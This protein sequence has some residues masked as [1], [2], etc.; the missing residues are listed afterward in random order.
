MGFLIDEKRQLFGLETNKTTYAFAVDNMGL[1]RHL[2]W[3][4]KVNN[5]ED[6]DVPALAEMSS[7]DPILDLTDEEYPVFG[8]MR[9]KEHCLKVNFAD[10]TRDIEYRYV[11]YTQTEET[12]VIHL[13]DAHYEFEFDLHYKVYEVQDLIERTVS[14]R[15]TGNDIIEIEKVHSGQIHLPYQDLTLTSSHGRWL[16]EFQEFKQPLGQ[17]KIVLENRRGISTHHHNP[18]FILD[19]QA[20]ETN[21][22][23]Y[24]GVLKLS[25][26]F[27]TIIEPRPYGGTLVQ[28][29]ISSHDCVISLQPGE[30]FMAPSMLVGYTNSG[31][32]AM[33]HAMNDLAKQHVLRDGVRPVLYN[34]WEATEF[35]VHC[36]EQI[37]L[38]K[39]AKEMGVELFV[40][41]DGWFGQRHSDA[42]G[43]GDWYV[44]T[45]KFP[46]GLTPLISAVKE[47]GMMFGIWIEPEMVNPPTQLLKDHPDWI[48]HFE[49]RMND[50]SRNQM[51]L[52][53]TLPEVQEFI[54]NMI[55]DLLANY[56]IDYIK[57]DANRPISQ[58]G[59]SRD[60]WYRHIEAVYD[61]ARRVKEKYPN[62]LLEACASGGGRVDYGMLDSFDDF[63]TSDNTD[64][65]DRLTIQRTYSYVYPIKA[66]RAWV[67]DANNR[68][69]I[70]LTFKFHSAMMGTLGMGCNILKFTEEEMELSRQLIEEYKEIRHIIQ[71]GDF[72]RLNPITSNNYQVY[73]YANEDEAVLFVFLPQTQISRLGACI[74]IRGLDADA[75]Y[76]FNLSDDL[77]IKSG[78]YLMN[79]GIQVKLSGDYA[80]TIIK[81]KKIA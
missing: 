55:D 44:N 42:D 69:T 58:T 16:A 9:Y 76:E 30:E 27:Q 41:D 66:M 67:T 8:G 46:E 37:A 15:N 64:A 2:Y 62:L 75:R 52:N 28:M 12:L 32:E 36:D 40:I 81:F 73:E 22:E 51:V 39:K 79:H 14:V 5:L 60:M 65:Y 70:P 77:I 61:I 25:G 26:N 31:F 53:V 63:W 13:K 23:V 38:A 72:Y 24:F 10:G 20:S 33:T 6:F 78:S 4:P 1:L 71:D 47:M 48:Y 34:S 50:T 45:D 17:G 49:N 29:G 56:E 59:I 7:N 54:F 18:F 80:S 57:W 43:L 21:G 74:K 3:G 11:G 35:D 68:S 19:H